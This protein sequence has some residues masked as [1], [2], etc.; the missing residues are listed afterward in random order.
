[1]IDPLTQAAEPEQE[2]KK[3]PE[4]LEVQTTPE[5]QVDKQPEEA[6]FT[7]RTSVPAILDEQIAQRREPEEEYFKL[8][9]L[10]VKMKHTETGDA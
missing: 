6:E 7:P 9:V 5:D 3:S 1:M 8:A 10:A 2:L 4:K